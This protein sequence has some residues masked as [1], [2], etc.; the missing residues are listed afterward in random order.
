MD[1]RP[2]EERAGA[3]AEGAGQAEARAGAG[4]VEDLAGRV[5]QGIGLHGLAQAAGV[6]DPQG[7]AGA[8]G[9]PNPHQQIVAPPSLDDTD[10]GVAAAGVAM[11]VLG[12]PAKRWLGELQQLRAYR[13]AHFDPDAIAAPTPSQSDV[14]YLAPKGRDLANV[15]RH[16]E[17]SAGTG[18]SAIQ[19]RMT[20]LLPELERLWVYDGAGHQ[21]WVQLSLAA[22]TTGSSAGRPVEL[23][24]MSDGTIQALVLATLLF[25][26]EPARVLCLDEPELNLHPAWVRRLGVWM[27]EGRP[28]SQLF[29]ST[30]S[31]ELL[32][33]LTAAFVRGDM[34]VLVFGEGGSRSPRTIRKLALAEV[35]SVLDEGWQLGDLY[36]VGDRRLGG[37]PW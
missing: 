4:R 2:A 8:K 19:A 3:G 36:R 25:A 26:P 15:L 13:C 29:V 21:R 32:D 34:A 6:H 16:I 23:Q 31:P 18:L 1:V 10:G 22:E 17:Q 11:E 27:D 12:P 9:I 28:A 24:Q 33:A 20:E 5:D 35:Q 37:W 14:R 7:L 30:H